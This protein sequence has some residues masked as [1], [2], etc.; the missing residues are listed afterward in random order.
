MDVGVLVT[1]TAESGDLSAV[2][3]RAETLGFA[4]L[5]IPE[6]P[7]IPVGHTTPFP[8]AADGVLPE[9]YNRWADPF[10]ALTVAAGVT[11]R[12]KLGTGICLLPERDP[13][14]TAKVIASLD[15]YSNGRVILGI[16]GG[17]LRE[18]TELMGTSFRLRWRRLRET[19][20]AMR[21]LWTQTET[22]YDGELVQFP[23]VRC[24]P[25]PVQQNGPP[26]LLGAHG[27][28]ALER[29]ARSYDGW[30][31][32]AHSPQALG[33]EI[34][35]LRKLVTEAGRDPDSVPVTPIIDPDNGNLSVDT[36]KRYQDAG[37]DGVV[38]FNQQMG[39]EIA[40]GKAHE[41][42]DRVAPIVDRA[43]GV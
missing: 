13:L 14:M 7:V 12:I 38:V 19:V 33:A 4:S 32:L 42:L 29:V 8:G 43:R 17:W 28:K 3:R 6:H 27:P 23:V 15:L 20:E 5:W 1:A 36:L 22:S 18:E 39:T 26:V 9:H 37:V 25:K 35:E 11:N 41:W 10:I 34:E 31:P 30:F 21:L 24:E 40:D 2:A 16:G